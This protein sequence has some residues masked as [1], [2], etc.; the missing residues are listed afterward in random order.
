[1]GSSGGVSQGCPAPGGGTGVSSLPLL[2]KHVVSEP[3]TRGQEGSGGQLPPVPVSTP[4]PR[5]CCSRMEP[6]V[7]GLQWGSRT[8][9][10]HISPPSWL[11]TADERLYKPKLS[12]ASPTLGGL[13]T[14]S[15]FTLE[16][17][18]CVF[19]NLQD[20]IVIWL[21]VAVPKGRWDAAR[22]RGEQPRAGVCSGL[23]VAPQSAPG[24]LL[25][26]VLVPAAVPNFKNS[27]MPGS[28][29]R[30]F[31]KFPTSALAYM[32][33]NTTLLNYPCHKPPREITVLRVGS[34]TSCAK[35]NTRP[36]CN[37]PLPGPGPYQ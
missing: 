17:P 2:T 15:T 23:P 12:T 36:T 29:E 11:L 14:S 8:P 26:P 24:S 27:V 9:P 22:P 30:A 34:E 1:M 7:R 32:T 28:P 3:K 33:L 10:L 25:I 5:Y 13:T 20:D 21:V 35:D 37:G 31:Q 6:R 4:S 18:R 19:T 16:Q